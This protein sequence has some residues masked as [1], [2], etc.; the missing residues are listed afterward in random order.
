MDLKTVRKYLNDYCWLFLIV[1]GYFVSSVLFTVL[2]I[3]VSS[4]RLGIAI[5]YGSLTPIAALTLAACLYYFA[6]SFRD[7]CMLKD[8]EGD[9]LLV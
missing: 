1:T 4:L 5:I 3:N 6:K 9:P 7:S 2:Y 8:R